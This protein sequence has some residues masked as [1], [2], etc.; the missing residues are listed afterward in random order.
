MKTIILIFAVILIGVFT[1]F[2]VGDIIYDSLGD[3]RNESKL[4]VIMLNDYNTDTPQEERSI[5]GFRAFVSEH[6]EKYK[7]NMNVKNFE[8][9]PNTIFSGNENSKYL[10]DFLNTKIC[11]VSTYPLMPL[12]TT[13]RY[14]EK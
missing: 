10:V 14:L 2:Y 6:F 9:D 3:D 1:F 13:S 8:I 4:I 7:Q 11:K 5:E 12:K